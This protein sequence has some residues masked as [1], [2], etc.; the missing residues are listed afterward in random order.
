MTIRSLK[1]PNISLA[2]LNV[3]NFCLTLLSLPHSNAEPERVFSEENLNK[4]ALGNKLLTET[5]ESLLHAKYGFFN[6]NY[7][8]NLWAPDKNMLKLF[9]KDKEKAYENEDEIIFEAKEKNCTRLKK[10][11]KIKKY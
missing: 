3:C 7:T 4:T 8:L 6:S 5:S 1:N 11:K 2:Y 10:Y 9:N